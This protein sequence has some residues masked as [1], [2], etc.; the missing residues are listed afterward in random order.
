[1]D[2]KLNDIVNKEVV[3]KTVKQP[4]YTS[5][6]ENKVPDKTVL[7]QINNTDKRKL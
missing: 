1:M 3:K 2:L 5:N 6:L 7:I 4:K